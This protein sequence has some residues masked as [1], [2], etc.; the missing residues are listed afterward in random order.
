MEQ[1]MKGYGFAIEQ[2]VIN[3]AA[4]TN[5]LKDMARSER[6]RTL[7]TIGLDEYS[8]SNSKLKKRRFPLKEKLIP[9]TVM[10]SLP[11]N[12]EIEKV[13]KKRKQIK[14]LGI[15]YLVL[16]GFEK[17][18]RDHPEPVKVETVDVANLIH[19]IDK[20]KDKHVLDRIIPIEPVENKT[21]AS[22][23]H[24]DGKNF[25]P[26][27]NPGSNDMNIGEKFQAVFDLVMELDLKITIEKK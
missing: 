11:I 2:H 23:F 5:I 14:R 16:L 4:E 19:D 18:K 12:E 6:F 13:S 10:L 9:F 25:I 24:R 1:A 3:E 15:R 8:I 27:K 17:W 7:V 26:G 22:E 21:V 20:A